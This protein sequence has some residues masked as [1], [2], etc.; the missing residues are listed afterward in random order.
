MSVRN[1]KYLFHPRS[2][3]LIGASDEARSVG[4]VLANNL[5][6]GGF[7][8]PIDLVNPRHRFI[9]GIRVYKEV[10][11]LPE[12]AD[13]AVIVTPPPTIPGIIAELAD[14]GT[15]AAIVISAGFSETAG[16]EHRQ[17]RQAMLDVARPY[18]LRIN[19]PNCLGVMV[20]GAG[21]NA[22][23]AHTSPLE[24]HL[25]FVAQSGAI[26]TSV[27]DWAKSRRIG[28]SH[29]VSLGNM[30]DVD[31]GDMLDYL[32]NDMATTAILLYIESVTQARK[33]M[34]AAR[35]ASRSKPVIVIKA[36]RYSEGARA[37]ASH[38]GALA[39]MD[40]VYDAAIS[41]A[42]M[43]RV[44][45]L[46]EL[47]EAVESLTA[48]RLPDGDSLAILSNG[49]GIGVLATDALI[50]Y[51]GCLA[52]LSEETIAQ[53][54]NVLPATWSH[55]NPVDI[56]GDAPGSRYAS[57]LEVLSGDLHL[58]ATLI[59]NCP[60]AVASATEAAQEVINTVNKH[61]RLCVLTSWVGEDAAKS[62]RRLF[63]NHGI[64]SYDTPEAA[65]RAFMQ[66]VNY[67]RNQELLMQTPPSI[68]EAFT[69]DTSVA[70][71]YINSALEEGR[72]WL[73]EPESKAVLSAYGIPCVPTVVA[74]SPVQA[75]RAAAEIGQPVALKILSPDITHKSDVGGVALDLEQAIAVQKAAEGML[76]RIESICPD[77]RI[78]GFTVQPMVRRP[79]SQELIIGVIEDS[80]FGPVLL[81]G[82]GGT[83]VE[84]INDKALGLPPL[85]MLLAREMMKRT[86]VYKLL[87]GYR[88]QP[89]ADLEAIA[90]TLVRLS[91]LVIDMEEIVELDINPLLADANGVIGLDTRIKV[92]AS[93]GHAHERLAICPY[94]KALEEEVPLGDGRTLLLRPIVPEDEPSLQRVFANLTAEEIRLRFFLPMKV[95]NHVS[96]ARFT[97]IDYDRE[98]ALILTESGIPGKTNIYGIVRIIADPDNEKAEYAIIV[99]HEMTGLGLGVFLMRRII[100]YARDRGIGELYGDV[101]AYNQPM[102]KLCEVMGFTRTRVPDEP[103]I[104]RVILKFD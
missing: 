6:S 87:E 56:I 35:A 63:M 10:A 77:A 43:L 91:Q 37:A 94:P 89:A 86:R 36:G 1:L 75:A 53:L 50:E 54:N 67:R 65:V 42:G 73:T 80:Q 8:G 102:L 12:P 24:G 100:D 82:H 5:L 15:R 83:A 69:P 64:P 7:D 81:F 84:V 79:G 48:G 28:F 9:G 57:A 62:A 93:S 98:M 13:L 40:E 30:A 39:G 44:H 31:F 60:T 52:K 78:D 45:S 49:G 72:D 88:D 61:R 97:Q 59:L 99:H 16:E 33:F 29:L 41:R 21:L 4:A 11:D 76:K 32:A 25:A 46:E 51:G 103:E 101:L 96:A 104:M 71:N 66:M 27:L 38:T 17:L 3:V 23:F 90:L 18:L 70:K 68:P 26:V 55:G 34:S 2:I 74:E 92:K 14:K 22:S 85:N 95:L 47:F 19:G 58:D 20:P